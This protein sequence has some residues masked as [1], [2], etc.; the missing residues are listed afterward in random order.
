MAARRLCMLLDDPQDND[1]W[2]MLA[3]TELII[4][5]ST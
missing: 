5:G 3:P 1:N 4:R 2:M